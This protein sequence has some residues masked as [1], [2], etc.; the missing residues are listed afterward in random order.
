MRLLLKNRLIMF[1]SLSFFS[2]EPFQQFAIQISGLERKLNFLP[3][4]IILSIHQPKEET[5]TSLY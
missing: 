1:F 4:F 5:Q 2:K 3:Y